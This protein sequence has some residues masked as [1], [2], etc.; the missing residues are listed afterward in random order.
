MDELRVEV[1]DEGDDA[2]Q[3][4]NQRPAAGQ[5]LGDRDT[6]EIAQIDALDEAGARHAE[7]VADLA[8]VSGQGQGQG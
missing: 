4:G 8:R 6:G 5:N 7:L 3:L 2:A 1:L